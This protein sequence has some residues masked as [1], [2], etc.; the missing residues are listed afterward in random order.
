MPTLDTVVSS[1]WVPINLGYCIKPEK[2]LVFEGV[3]KERAKTS[4]ANGDESRP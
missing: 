4:I 3:F 1:T 2:L